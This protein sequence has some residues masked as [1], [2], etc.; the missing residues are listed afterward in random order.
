[1]QIRIPFYKIFSSEREFEHYK[2]TRRHEIELVQGT[3]Q[4]MFES[5]HIG[6]TKVRWKLIYYPVIKEV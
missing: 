4:F 5:T 3:G 6:H 1:M 2:F